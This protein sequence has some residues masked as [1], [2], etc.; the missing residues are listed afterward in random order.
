[1]NIENKNNKSWGKIPHVIEDIN[2]KY[3]PISGEDPDALSSHAHDKMGYTFGDH[4]GTQT[5]PF[6]FSE[7]K[8]EFAEQIEYYY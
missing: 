2:E 8:D 3:F 6:P 4:T 7:E 1:M 5:G